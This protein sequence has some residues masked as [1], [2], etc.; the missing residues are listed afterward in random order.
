MQNGIV[1]QKLQALDHTLVELRSLGHVSVKQLNAN[2]QTQRAVER[3]LQ[4]LVEV[5][6][7][8]CQRLLAVSG[9]SPAT[10]SADAIHRCIE[11]GVL[12]QDENYTRM[13]QL[14]NFLVHRYERSDPEALVN[15][16]N[17]HLGDFEKFRDE[18]LA[19]VQEH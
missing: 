5:V 2:W 4:V 14:R 3:S 18:I 7:D 1:A 15:M 8:V 11:M 9:Q 16:V 13:L 10:T 6:I 17:R 12:T 19:Y